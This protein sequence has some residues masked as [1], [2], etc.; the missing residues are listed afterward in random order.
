VFSEDYMKWKS[1]VDR[2]KKNVVIIL[3][4]S[5]IEVNVNKGINNLIPAFLKY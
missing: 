2:S 3:N 4:Y 1:E 5:N